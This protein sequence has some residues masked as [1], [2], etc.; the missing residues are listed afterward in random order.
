MHLSTAER[1]AIAHLNSKTI[2]GVLLDMGWTW[3]GKADSDIFEEFQKG[4]KYIL[5]PDY[6]ADVADREGLLTKVVYGFAKAEDLAVFEAIALLGK[7]S[8]S[9]QSSNNFRRKRSHDKHL[10]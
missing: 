4:S 9:R 6:R 7:V 2:S 8:P 3:N 10:G 5:V 1:R